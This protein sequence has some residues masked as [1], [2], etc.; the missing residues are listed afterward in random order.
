[1]TSMRRRTFLG[2]LA[3]SLAPLQVRAEETLEPGYLGSKLA[4]GELPPLD[5]RLPNVPRLVN[6]GAMGRKPGRHGG[7]VRMTIGGQKDIRLM[8]INGYTRLVGYDETLQL[9]PDV[10]QSFEQVEDRVF[11]FRLRAGHRWSDGHPLTAEDFRYYW[12]DVLL[13]KELKPGGPPPSMMSGGKP[14]VFEIVDE[15]TVRYS[16]DT[17]NPEFLPR[18]AAPQPLPIL[19]PSHYMRRFHRKYQ[20]AVRLGALVRQERVEEWTDLHTK[21]SRT[22]RPENPDLPTLDPWRNTIAPPAEQFVFERNPFYHRVDEHGRQLPYIDRFVLNVSSSAIISA[23]TGAGESDLQVNG[24]QFT[25]YTFLKDAEKRYPIKVSLWKQIQGSRVALLPNLNCSDEVWRTLFQDV[26]MRRALSLGIDRHEIN[27]ALFF[28]LC[29]ESADTMLPESPLYK[30]EYRTAWAT[31][32]PD[33]ANRLLDEIGLTERDED[34]VRL[35]P[36]GRPAQIIVETAGESTLETDVLELVTDH[37]RQIGLSLFIRTSQRDIFRKRAMAG[38][39]IM[40][41]WMGLDNAVATPDMPPYQLAPSSDDQMQWPQWGINY[42]SMGKQGSAPDLPE[43][44]RLVQLLNDWT[45]SASTEERRAIWT[46]ML[47]IYS[48]QVFSIGIVNG[49]RQPIVRSKRLRNVPEEGLYGFDPTCYL[50]IYMPD[51]FWFDEDA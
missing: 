1:M 18:L 26:R 41:V 13:D 33:E 46:E 14:P 45:R 28:G 5:D 21:M 16:W 11:T 30:P 8:T 40:S 12:E 25:D 42:L 44:E 17:P 31:Y 27:L 36:D 47:G 37:W 19:L 22:Y 2:L 6:L 20:D 43:A 34:G 3:S 51:T 35:L 49:S 23:K 9:Q 10:L 50:G 48:D 7:T 32:D 24:L 29:Q 15:F 4:A 38:S 39:V